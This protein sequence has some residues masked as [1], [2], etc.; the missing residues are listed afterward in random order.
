MKNTPEYIIHKAGWL[1]NEILTV[2]D[3]GVTLSAHTNLKR[4]RVLDAR[5]PKIGSQGGN[6]TKCHVLSQ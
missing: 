2:V 4:D 3:T 6:S 5:D 1:M